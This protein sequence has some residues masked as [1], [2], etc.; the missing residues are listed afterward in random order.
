LPILEALAKEADF[1]LLLPD[2]N[3]RH[4]ALQDEVRDFVKTGP[5]TDLPPVAKPPLASPPSHR[6]YY[7]SPKAGHSQAFQ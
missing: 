3:R 5:D 4:R 6:G 2:L 7:N 1:P